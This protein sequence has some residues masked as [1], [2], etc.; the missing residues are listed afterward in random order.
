VPSHKKPSNDTDFGNYLAGLI[1]GDGHF[2]VQKQLVI[3]FHS[4]DVSLAY[5]IKSFVGFGQV[6]LVKNKQAVIYVVSSFSGVERVLRLVAGKLRT[7]RRRAQAVRNILCH[8]A[9][10]ELFS[11]EMFKLNR[12]S[13]LTDY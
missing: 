12:E 1:D 5:F 7:E 9:F 8:S 11:S 6:Y 3:T 4:R 10:L 2:S 13:C